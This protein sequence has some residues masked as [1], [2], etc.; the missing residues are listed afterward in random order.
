VLVA[1]FQYGA[2]GYTASA[3]THL[4]FW[5]QTA[6][7]ADLP[8]FSV[9][10]NDIMAGLLRFDLGSLPPDAGIVS[11]TLT[12]YASDQSNANL[13]SMTLHRVLRE[14]VDAQANWQQPR[15]AQAWEVLGCN[16]TTLDR[17]SEA[18]ATVLLDA[19]YKFYTIDVSDLVRYWA[20]HPLENFGMVFKGATGNHVEYHFASAEHGDESKRP[21]LQIT[22]TS[23]QTAT[24]TP[25]PTPSTQT[26]DVSLLEGWNLVS[27]PVAPDSTDPAVIF[28]PVADSV[29][30]VYFWSA[31]E[32]IWKTYDPALPPG[33]NTLTAVDERMGLWMHMRAAA[34]LTVSGQR[35]ATTQI[36]LYV[37]WNMVG[38]PA[39]EPSEPAVAIAA[40]A[41]KVSTILGYD[42]E[43]SGNPWKRYRPAAPDFAND[44]GA[45]EP[46]RG[47]WMLVAE[48]C[49]WELPY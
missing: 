6:N 17:T 26:A 46:G 42:S 5:V 14:W 8:D 15:D 28:A 24:P 49:T 2:N 44:L 43:S 47:Y 7:Y 9:R 39:A 13:M 19:A 33:A 29:S 36:P 3:D 11:A 38:F 27:I 31:Q 48:A 25:T 1:T 22:Y 21:M 41:E 45:L 10:A 12:L 40:I 30:L 16:G 34:T 37:G 23:G 18:Y 20:A 35:P 32:G 4:D